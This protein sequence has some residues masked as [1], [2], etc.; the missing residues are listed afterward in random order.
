MSG[1]AKSLITFAKITSCFPG[2]ERKGVEGTAQDFLLSTISFH[3]L[4]LGSF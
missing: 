2:R 4:H 3:Q 1:V